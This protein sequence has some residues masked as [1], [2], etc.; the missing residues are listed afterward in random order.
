MD[1]GSIYPVYKIAELN[2]NIKTNILL[3]NIVN[4]ITDP[5]AVQI[6]D[7]QNNGER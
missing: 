1:Y 6:S 7:E 3:N 5:V 2:S 4:K